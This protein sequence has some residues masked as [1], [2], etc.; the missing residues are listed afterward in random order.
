MVAFMIF[1]NH[2]LIDMEKDLKE[3]IFLRSAWMVFR[4]CAARQEKA[5]CPNVL[6]IYGSLQPPLS[7]WVFIGNLDFVE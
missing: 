5:E 2:C 4:V 1:N 6:F 3:E 7:S